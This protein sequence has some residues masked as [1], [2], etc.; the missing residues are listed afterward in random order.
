MDVF[1]KEIIK[2]INKLTMASYG[3]TLFLLLVVFFLKNISEIEAN[4]TISVFILLTTTIFSIALP[5][6][7]RTSF[8]QKS[9]K[10]KKLD[11]KDYLKMKR[12]IVLSVSL[13]TICALYG[14]FAL[15][16]KYHLYLSILIAIWG[17]YSIFPS[18]NIIKKELKEFNVLDKKVI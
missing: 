15:I 18:N 2:K 3:I 10:N 6:L 7:F 5:I 13:G 12:F 1:V 16:F 9:I 8:Y 14:Y 4:R 11:I 17:I